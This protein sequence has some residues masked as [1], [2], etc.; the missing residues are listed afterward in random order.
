[1][2][3]TARGTCRV[4]S[5]NQTSCGCEGS[6][7][8]CENLTWITYSHARNIIFF[9]YFFSLL[10]INPNC[11]IRE[12]AVRSRA[13]TSSAAAALL[14]WQPHLILQGY[15]AVGRGSADSWPATIGAFPGP[16]LHW[17]QIQ[18]THGPV[19][20]IKIISPDLQHTY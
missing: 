11:I 20:A 2:Y 4:L 8:A 6:D 17:V 9:K 19:R 16:A 1:M 14:A 12:D 7:M 3:T 5:L 10:F 15:V 13:C 18:V